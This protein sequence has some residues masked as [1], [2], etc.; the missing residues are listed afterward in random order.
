[1]IAHNVLQALKRLVHHARN[2][3]LRL[4]LR[5]P[6]NGG[7]WGGSAVAAR[8]PLNPSAQNLI[9]IS[10]LANPFPKLGPE[11]LHPSHP[12]TC[13][14]LLPFTRAVIALRIPSNRVPSAQIPCCVIQNPKRSS[15]IGGLGLA[16]SVIICDEA[17]EGRQPGSIAPPGLGTIMV[18]LSS[19]GLR[20][21]PAPPGLESANH[22]YSFKPGHYLAP[23]CASFVHA[24]TRVIIDRT[25]DLKSAP[26][27]STG[28]IW[29]TRARR[30]AAIPASAGMTCASK[31]IPIQM[32]PMPS[33]T[34]KSIVTGFRLDVYRREP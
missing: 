19:H 32:I 24:S 31:G 2:L 14:G 6:V 3:L 12:T 29:E 21:G 16:G 1:V 27:S 7:L 15:V 28:V 4:G 11:F 30:N 25:S 8:Q 26:H 22:C 34:L 20:R 23:P 17:P 13:V 33:F 18:G 5:G 10:G 9:V